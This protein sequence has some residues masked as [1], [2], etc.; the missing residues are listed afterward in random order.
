[1]GNICSTGLQA[2]ICDNS[3]KSS[4]PVAPL[5]LSS[6]PCFHSYLPK[7]RSA[8]SDIYEIE[9]RKIGFGYYGDVKKC[10]HRET[11][12][13]RAVKILN[14]ERTGN[15][16]LHENW[17]LKQVEVLSLIDH[18]CFIRTHEYFE[19]RDCFYLV[20]DYH[21]EGDLMQKLRSNKKLSEDLSRKVIKN[22]LIAVKYLHS[23]KAVHRDL[24]P[25]N[26]LVSER[27]GET[28]VKVID[29]DTACLVGE[30]G[31]KGIF[32]TALYM[33]P[34]MPLGEYN[35]K[36]DIWSI[37]IIL[38]N[39]LTGTMPYS[40]LSDH[41]IVSNI[42][43]LQVNL[44]CPELFRV[45]N[46][47]K[48]F[49]SRLLQ[50]DPKKRISAEEALRDPWISQADS[51]EAATKCEK[52]LQEIEK[53][54][55]KNVRVKETLIKHFSIIKDFEDL[56]LVFLELDSD[57]NGFI[58]ACDIEAMYTKIYTEGEAHAKTEDLLGSMQGVTEEFI[59]YADFLNSTINLR[60]VLD[61]KRI[62]RFL[63]K[64]KKIAD[65]R[66][67]GLEIGCEETDW[68]LDLKDKIDQDITPGD[69]RDVMIDKLFVNF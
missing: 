50:K 21:K 11:G 38:F 40:G 33:A 68:F 37:G 20:M 26:I 25:E 63:D 49:L 53:S 7:N 29:F 35:E 65:D 31:L 64:R 66:V 54:K 36:C 10:I 32:G 30:Q 22:V 8:F 39:M 17:F 15:H 60:S 2:N 19:D 43:K 12:I 46:D 3:P 55:V 61:D 67:A 14:R 4:A 51:R 18:P 16:F 23:V 5:S 48:G 27:N 42:Q 44:S 13:I 24:K 28:I 1:M 41:Q 47:C 9:N 59:T 58:S 34:E 62:S 57:H 52:I 45:S 56:D 6:I 69:L